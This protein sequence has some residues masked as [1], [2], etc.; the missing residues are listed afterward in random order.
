[1]VRHLD[2]LSL[3]P[4]GEE[5]LRSEL[6][7][8]LRARKARFDAPHL[9]WDFGRGL[10]IRNQPLFDL[11]EDADAY[12]SAEAIA[13][14]PLLAVRAKASDGLQDTPEGR[15]L[16]LL[17]GN[18]WT[19]W[20]ERPAIILAERRIAA[21]WLRCRFCGGR[22]H[23]LRLGSLDCPNCGGSLGFADGDALAGI[24]ALREAYGEA[25]AGLKSGIRAMA[26]AL[27]SNLWR[28]RIG[29]STNL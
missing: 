21:R 19:A 7:S 9:A 8:R 18:A 11:A 26:R 3:D 17:E 15:R 10:D 23:P 22:E 4:C 28:W 16:A 29:A 20:K 12:I 24:E 2:F 27:P 6:A 1:M 13:D 14:G 25:E 5:A